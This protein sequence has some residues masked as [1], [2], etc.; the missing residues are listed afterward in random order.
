MYSIIGINGELARWHLNEDDE[1]FLTFRDFGPVWVIDDPDI[2][3]F[4]LNFPMGCIGN[5]LLPFIGQDELPLKVVK[6]NV[7]LIE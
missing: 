6:L 4:V 2:P 1:V 3:F 7:S 5:S